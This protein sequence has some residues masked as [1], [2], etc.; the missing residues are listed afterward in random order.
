MI[1]ERERYERAFQ[2]FHMT[3]PAWDRLVRRRER[4]RRNQ[5][6]AA[7][8]VG[9]AVFVAAV[10]IVTSGG[11]FDRTQPA[12]PGG[13]ESGA[14][15]TGPAQTGP[16]QS[17]TKYAYSGPTYTLGPVT[18]ED[19]A[20]GHEFARAWRDGDGEAAAALFSSEGTFD[21]RPPAILPA[22]HD[23]FRAA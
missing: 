23:W 5:R 13:K 6:I 8:I 18:D 4:K 16:T 10:W 14:T 2:Q 7:G 9:I 15:E 22:L 3:E 17:G 1:D 20:L 12:V 11:W 21:G 19:I